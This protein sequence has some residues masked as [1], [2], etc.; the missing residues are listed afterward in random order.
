MKNPLGRAF[1]VACEMNATLDNFRVQAGIDNH[2]S[3]IS[4]DGGDSWIDLGGGRRELH[5]AFQARG[6]NSQ[7]Q[8]DWTGNIKPGTSGVHIEVP[9]DFD[10]D[11]WD[12][13][14]NVCLKAFTTEGNED[15]AITP[16]EAKILTINYD[17]SVTLKVNGSADTLVNAPGVY[18]GKSCPR[19]AVDLLLCSSCAGQEITGV[20][21][22][23]EP[24]DDYSQNLFTYTWTM[25]EENTSI[26]FDFRIVNKI[27]L[28]AALQLAKKPR[29]V[30]NMTK[31]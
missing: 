3:F 14:A 10:G 4:V 27:T 16:A 20:S 2:Q 31:R 5:G 30:T 29:R 1:P 21:I 12:D 15:S 18:M 23:G 19:K 11:V 28:N 9:G 6:P 22:N 24:T 17:A 26:D 13:L 25:G 7:N 8:G